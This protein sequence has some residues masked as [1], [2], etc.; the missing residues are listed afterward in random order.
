[1][2]K[3]L[4]VGVASLAIGAAMVVSAASASAHTARVTL[5]CG[6]TGVHLSN[7][8][9]GGPNTVTDTIDGVTTGPISFRT[10]YNHTTSL[11][12]RSNHS[13]TVT[14]SAWDDPT[15]S[16]GWSFT[17]TMATDKCG[18]TVPP[19]SSSPAPSESSTTPSETSAPPSETSTPPS[20][21]PTPPA[22][23]T[24][25]TKPP[26]LTPQL[27][28]CYTRP[29]KPPTQS[30]TSKAP[31]VVI[32]KSSSSPTPVLTHNAALASTGA[33]TG[34]GLLYGVVLILGG[35]GMVVIGTK[36]RSARK[37]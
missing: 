12:Q 9:A 18:S 17:Q 2:K 22:T 20:E 5:S 37:H 25:A 33:S 7:Y 1:M 26:C 14:V 34:N 8:N 24:S 11:D 6:A 3:T 13:V 28:T 21:T 10:T 27:P 19:S 16:H 32:K 36:R 15:G 35:L 4:I 23:S 29:T 31:V 30:S